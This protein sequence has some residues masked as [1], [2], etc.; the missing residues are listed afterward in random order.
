MLASKTRLCFS[1]F[2]QTFKCP[3]QVL[4]SEFFS[5]LQQEHPVTMVT[6]LIIV[7]VKSVSQYIQAC[8]STARIRIS[9]YLISQYFPIYPSMP[10]CS[11]SC[12]IWLF[13]L[14]I[15]YL[16]NPPRNFHYKML[17]VRVSIRL[18]FYRNQISTK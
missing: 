2:S 17:R 5:R 12:C 9:E 1:S 11:Q 6:S 18:F 14:N 4:T 8:P 10:Q 13:Y 15:T 3:E 16:Y 7:I